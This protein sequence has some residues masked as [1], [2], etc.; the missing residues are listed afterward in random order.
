MVILKIYGIQTFFY[1]LSLHIIYLLFSSNTVITLL[2]DLKNKDR[3]RGTI[4]KNVK[5]IDVLC[6]SI[7][8]I[9]RNTLPILYPLARYS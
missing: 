6:R 9:K 2:K 8:K 1:C 7:V 3:P 4:V 5:D